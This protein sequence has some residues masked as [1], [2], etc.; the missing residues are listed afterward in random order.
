MSRPMTLV[1]KILARASAKAQVEPGDIVVA[2]VDVSVMHEMS[3]WSSGHVFESRVGGSLRDPDRM[4]AVFDH[5][6]SPPNEETANMLAWDRR[7]CREHGMR[8]F[9]C[10]SGNLHHTMM[11]NGLVRPGA[12]L[13]GSDSHSS[14]HGVVGAF[15]CS[16]GNDVFASM[17]LP[18][19]K[20]W[21]R[22]P[23]AID[24]R[25]VGSTPPGTLPR[26]V[27]L[28]LVGQI[29]EGGANYASLRFSGEYVEGLPFWDRWLFPL[30]AV[31]VGAKCGY[32]VPDRVTEDYVR[33]VSSEPYELVV[34]DPDAEY[35]ETW[36]FDVSQIPP[37]VALPPSMG[38]VHPLSTAAGTPIDY[39]DLGGHG[40]GRLEDFRSVAEVL[41]QS[42]ETLKVPLN[43]VPSSRAVFT[44]ALAEGLVERLHARGGSW[45][46]PSTG[47]NQSFNMGAL[48]P[49]EAMI[50]TQSRNF[51][52]RNGSPDGSVYLASARSVA[53]AALA[54][55]IVAAEGGDDD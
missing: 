38:N 25:L 9:D 39:A 44:E 21:L 33:S 16:L 32:I 10:G 27:A 52:G 5:V 19:S 45:F 42:D 11:T 49:G 15:A 23:H 26:D 37:Q 40:G 7:F 2:D 1:E 22:V 43:L 47:A 30:I 3:T 53:R 17:V 6:F 29:G 48:S 35:A 8:F 13:V 50:T 12:L 14:V 51:P 20:A 46:P 28:W 54:G 36:T 55:K 18:H 4:F 34:D 41:D 31:D 24:V